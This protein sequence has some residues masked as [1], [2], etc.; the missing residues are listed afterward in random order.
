MEHLNVDGFIT[1]IVATIV[2]DL[3]WKLVDHGV[4]YTS[5]LGRFR[6]VVF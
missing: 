2:C 6:C 3:E 5:I 1:K 4:P